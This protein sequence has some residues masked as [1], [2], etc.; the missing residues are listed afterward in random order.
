MYAHLHVKW[1]LGNV[2]GEQLTPRY[3]D[4]RQRV[5]VE[6]LVLDRTEKLV[7]QRR[8][9]ADVGVLGDEASDRDASSC[10]APSNR[11]G[12]VGNGRKHEPRPVVV[13]IGHDHFHASRTASGTIDLSK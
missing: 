6:R 12:V 4:A 11:D 10:W 13:A 3:D 1:V 7:P 9:G 5:D 2:V 8:V